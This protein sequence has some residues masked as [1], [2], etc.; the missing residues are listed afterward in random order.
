MPKA[1][2]AA[3][4]RAREETERRLVQ[5]LED[6]LRE[7]GFAAIGVNAV[8]QRAGVD[9]V[10]IYRYFDGLPG[11]L[12]RYAESGSFWPTLDEILGADR[13][14]LREP[15]PARLVARVLG[16]YARALRARPVTLEL[17]AW[18]CGQRT[19]LTAVLEDARERAMEQLYAELRDAG[20]GGND[21]L[22]LT[23]GAL[24]SAGVHYLAMRGRFI[25]SFAGI[26][27]G[28]EAGWAAV[29]E[30]TESIYRG[31]AA[32]QPAET[33]TAATEKPAA[34]KPASTKKKR[35]IAGAPPGRGGR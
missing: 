7:E 30:A 9:K 11:L 29:E 16:G 27:I 21:P 24:L 10:L 28:S 32:L 13:A 25:P 12:R 5:A 14:V 15:D 22:Q 31:L 17:L 23:V 8:A 2:Q 26:A 19:D 35:V 1:K 3:P 33:A 6:V 20:V 4:P 34:G 18:E